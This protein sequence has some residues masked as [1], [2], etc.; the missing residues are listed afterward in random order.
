MPVDIDSPEFLEYYSSKVGEEKARQEIDQYNVDML[1]DFYAG[2]Y[3]RSETTLVGESEL[4]R[5]EKNLKKAREGYFKG[6]ADD[7]A[8]AAASPPTP[9]S[10]TGP[11]PEASSL[12]VADTGFANP[13]VEGRNT[14]TKSQAIQRIMSRMMEIMQAGGDDSSRESAKRMATAEVY[15]NYNVRTY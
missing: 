11:S 3:N 1:A 13:Y 15:R 4:R 8:S 6:R 9:A 14:I 12:S 10:A 2:K 5:A 7:A